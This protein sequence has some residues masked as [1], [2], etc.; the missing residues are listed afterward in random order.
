M[1][2]RNIEQQIREL[3]AHHGVTSERDGISRMAATITGL[4]GDDVML[5]EVEQLLANMARQKS[6][7][8]RE[9]LSLQAQ[10]LQEK[11]ASRA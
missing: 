11:R 5:D 1:P 10:Y 2:T 3:A 8:A 7:P 6:L 4:S 9:C